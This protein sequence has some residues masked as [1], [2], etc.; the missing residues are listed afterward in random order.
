MFIEKEVP[1]IFPFTHNDG[2]SFDAAYRK[3]DLPGLIQNMKHE[4]TRGKGELNS[5]ILLKSPV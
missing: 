3:F 2:E 1:T 4:Q 5:M